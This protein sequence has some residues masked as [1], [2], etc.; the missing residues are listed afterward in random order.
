MPAA[1]P[2]TPARRRRPPPP[3]PRAGRAITQHAADCGCE[4]LVVGSR[5]LGLSKKALMSLMGVGS[6]SD[7]VLN[8]AACNVVL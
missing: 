1:A 4:S 2:H 6:V 5:G 7:Y 8:H 3:P